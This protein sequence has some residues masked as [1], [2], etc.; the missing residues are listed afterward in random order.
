M[1]VRTSVVLGKVLK[2]GAT[3]VLWDKAFNQRFYA[4]EMVFFII[5]AAA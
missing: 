5:V 3:I 1:L 2:R 4:G